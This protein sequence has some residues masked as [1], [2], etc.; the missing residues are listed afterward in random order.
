MKPWFEVD[1]EGL[2]ALQEGKPKRFVLFELA[3]NALDEEITLCNINIDYRYGFITLTVED[4]SPEGFR[5][6]SHSWTLFADTYKR[7]NPEKRGRF[8]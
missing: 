1:K 8:N 7:K 5:D 4:D 3:Q 6:I 2:K